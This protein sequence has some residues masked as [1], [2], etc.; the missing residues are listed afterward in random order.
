M[1]SEI[2]QAIVNK[3]LELY[4][5]YTIYDEDIPQNFKTPCFLITVIEQNYS[6]RLNTKFKSTVSFDVAYFSNQKTETRNDC[7]NMQLVLL[8]NFDLV[9]GYRILNKQANITDDVLHFIFDINYSEIKQEISDKMQKHQTIILSKELLRFT[10]W[11]D[12]KLKVWDDVQFLA[13]EDIKS[14]Q[15]VFQ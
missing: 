15:A 7:Y 3:L 9:G 4:P 12:L 13:W 1:T 11:D 6:K 10:I 8:R 5:S 2:K 14:K